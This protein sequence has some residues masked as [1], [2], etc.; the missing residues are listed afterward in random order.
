MKNAGQKEEIKTVY[1]GGQI[2]STRTIINTETGEVIDRYHA[3]YILEKP[4]RPPVKEKDYF[5][6]HFIENKK[7]VLSLVL[8]NKLNQYDLSI[9]WILEQCIPWQNNIVSDLNTLQYLNIHDLSKKYKLSRNSLSTSLNRLS[10]FGI[11]SFLPF[12]KN[13]KLIVLN[14]YLVYRGIKINPFIL[15]LFAFSNFKKIHFIKKEYV[16]RDTISV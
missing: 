13:Q 14:P 5:A 9:L 1:S 15:D 2:D 12:E 8:E 16:G 6:K 10:C 3:I 4:I 7:Q 11:V